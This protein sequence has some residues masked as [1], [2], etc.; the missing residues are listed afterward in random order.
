MN[1]QT[2]V[3]GGAGVVGAFIA[4]AFGGWSEALTFLLVA[5]GA[6]ILTGL[7]ASVHE[8]RGLNSAVGTIGLARKGLMIL[9]ILLAH[10]IDILLELDSMTMT[11][12]IYF[13]IA[14]ELLSITENL[15]RSGVPLPDKMRDIITVLKT[16]GGVKDDATNDQ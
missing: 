2:I 8:G 10:R 11:A 13:Y 14:N 6:D 1:G 5:I 16:K 9:V 3:N 7:Y 15:G 12:A 4:F